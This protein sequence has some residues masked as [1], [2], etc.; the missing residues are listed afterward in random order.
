MSV[1]EP[2]RP[3][4]DALLA[5]TRQRGKLKVFFGASAGVGK[6]YAMLQEAQRLRAQGLDVLVGL[7]ET[8]G[9]SETAALLTGLEV[10]LLSHHFYRGHRLAEFDLDGVLARHPAVVL[11]DE[12]AHS[13][14]PG[15]RHPK[16]WQ[17]VEELLEAGIDVFTTVNVQHL[18]SLNDI[19][20]GITGIRVRET[21]PD[22]VFDGADEVVLVDLTPDDLRQRLKEGKVYLAGQAERAIEHFFRKGNLM[23][24]R[25]TP[26]L[27]RLPEAQRRGI[28]QTLKLAGELGAETATLAAPDEVQAVLAYA[29][30]HNLGKIVIGRRQRESF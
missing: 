12:L 22:R 8:H 9:R 26:R 21:V 28:L 6:T 1:D 13:N 23:A 2:R 29:R 17:D 5:K 25:E 10:Q 3:D 4:P 14:V 24:L 20:G 27:H 19:V 7:V 30:E 18:E 11:V 15:S 16:R